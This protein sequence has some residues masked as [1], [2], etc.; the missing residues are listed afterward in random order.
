MQQ[1]ILK[2]DALL[3]STKSK[4]GATKNSISK[5]FKPNNN[6]S[7][8]VDVQNKPLSTKSSVVSSKNSISNL[9]KNLQK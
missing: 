1:D 8:S 3:K 5:D 2:K 6:R 7:V 9:K 4:L